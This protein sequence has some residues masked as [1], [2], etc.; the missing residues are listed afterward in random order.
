LLSVPRFNSV[1]PVPFSADEMF[2]LVADVEKYPLF[3]PLC[4]SL[5][6]HGRESAPDGT[7]SITATMGIGYKAIREQFTTLV[8]LDPAARA[9]VVR[10]KNGP[11]RRLENVWGFTP[12]G[13]Q[14]C[15]VHFAIDYEFSSPLLAVI[16]G[17]VFD[18]AFRRFAEAFEERATVVYGCRPTASPNALI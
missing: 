3:V 7:G 2:A 11:F 9:I 1:R 15:D 17:A 4:E 8:A 12:Q 5:T 10:H 13:E 14:S 6:V 18:K 16:M